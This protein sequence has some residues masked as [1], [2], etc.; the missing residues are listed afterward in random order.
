VIAASVVA[1]LNHLL[2]QASWAPRRL[3]AFT[4][5]SAMIELP[6][7]SVTF[8]INAEGL[9]E[10]ALCDQPDVVVSL[11]ADTPLLVVQGIERVLASAHVSGNAEFATELSFVLRNLRWDAEE[12]LSRLIG[13]IAA[14][15]AVRSITSLW[16]WQRSILQRLNENIG[17]Y[18]IE[19]SRLLVPGREAA[20]FSSQVAQL[21]DGIDGLEDRVRQLKQCT[22]LAT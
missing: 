13:D 4:G 18:L 19:E 7:W 8:A 17:E 2:G 15:R 14:R 11:P 1:A 12:D 21:A 6:P 5:R 20:G 9:C 10:T 22:S 16:A 3:A